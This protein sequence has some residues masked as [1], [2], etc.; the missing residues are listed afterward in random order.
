[1]MRTNSAFFDRKTSRR[2]YEPVIKQVVWR[3]KR[4][5]TGMKENGDKNM[6]GVCTTKRYMEGNCE[7]GPNRPGAIKPTNNKKT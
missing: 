7:G 6:E 2:D 5:G 3:I 1:M 4:R